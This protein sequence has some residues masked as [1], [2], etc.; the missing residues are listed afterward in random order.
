MKAIPPIKAAL[1]QHV[2]RAVYQGGY[3]WGQS[4]KAS[5]VLPSPT[6]WGW[7]KIEDGFFLAKLDYPTRASEVCYELVSCK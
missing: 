7:M 6:S 2:K 5:P 3:V 4:L 1:E